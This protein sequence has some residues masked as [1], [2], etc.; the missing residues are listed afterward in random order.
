MTKSNWE[1]T[2]LQSSYHFDND[3]VDREGDWYW[4]LGRVKNTWAQELENIKQQVRP[5]TWEN[6]KYTMGQGHVSPMLEQEEY[7]I[8]QG[9]GDP[10]MTLLEVEDNLTLYPNLQRLVD[11]FALEKC[12][13]RLHVQRTGQVWN[14]HID[15]IAQMFPGSP[16]EDIVRIVVML[17]DWVPGHFYLYGTGVFD[18]W[19]AGDV[20]WFDWLNVPHGTANASHSP[21]C[22]LQVW[23]IRTER[24]MKIL[25]GEIPLST[26]E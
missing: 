23:G 3:V 5:L 9:G 15:K 19:K 13:H 16:I 8:L 7:D 18:H 2:K 20:H 25:S 6:R 4:P 26:Y 24:T 17:E 14:M 21:R 10:K 11:F 1:F 22:S 12:M